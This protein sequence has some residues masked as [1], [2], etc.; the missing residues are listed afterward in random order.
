MPAVAEA[1]SPTDTRQTSAGGR[2]LASVA[3]AGCAA[4]AV[5]LALQHPLAP[6]LALAGVLLLAAVQAAWPPLWL[7]ALPA[8]MPWLGLGAWTGW[9]VVE[10]MDLVLLALAAGA[11]LRWALKPWPQVRAS[12]ASRRMRAWGQLLLML[13]AASVLVGLVRGLGDLGSTGDL[14]LGWWHGW[15]EPLNALRLAKSTVAMLLMLPL[16]WALQQRPNQRCADQLGLGLALALAGT[17]LWCVWERAAFTGLLNMSADYR[18]TGPFWETHVG[19]AALDACLALTLPFALR[20]W[21]TVRSPAALAAA[22]VVVL[23]GVYAGLTTFSRIV[24]LALPV[25]ALVLWWL[26]RQQMP[27]PTDAAP[28][29]STLTALLL[30]LVVGGL[31]VWL[32]PS[33]GYRGLLAL[34][35]NVVVLLLLAPRSVKQSA[36]IWVGAWALGL[37]LAAAVLVAAPLVGKGVYIAYAGLSL[38]TV[39]LLLAGGGSVMRML[40]GAGFVAQLAASAAVAVGW[41]GAAAWPAAAAAALLPALAWLAL[42]TRAQPAWQTD[43]RWLGGVTVMLAMALAAVAVFGGGAFMAS[44]LAQTESD[45]SGRWQ[46]FRDGLALNTGGTALWLGQGLGRYADLY[47]LNGRPETHPGDI[48]LVGTPGD[49]LVRMVAGNHLQGHSEMLR[50]SQRI[51]PPPASGLTVTLE[52]RSSAPVTLVIDLCLKHLLYDTDCRSAS[53]VSLANANGL[54]RLRVRLPDAGP[55][56]ADGLPRFT[57]FSVATETQRQPIDLRSVSLTDASGN[58]LLHNGSFT[59][60][61][62]RWFITSDKHHLPWH[63][64]NL[65]VHLLVEQGLLGLTALLALTLAAVAGLTGSLRQHPLAPALAAALVGCWVVGLVD[66]VLDLP[67]TATWLLLLTGMALN[68]HLPSRAQRREHA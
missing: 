4:L 56:P 34:L 35:G 31:G 27:A 54:Q 37:L 28:A 43:L 1:A 44:R 10:E 39:A 5:W 55:P 36:G 57:V 26:Q 48:R 22:G 2:V 64:K 14:G 25:G 60:G 66:S 67:R 12:R 41:G 24:Y 32:F 42:G 51:A 53:A 52:L 62:A 63:A 6:A 19:G 47:A 61:L 29:R 11:Y 15:R 13:W 49:A 38:V 59:D 9:T 68:L 8:L 45:G 7:I 21:W 23:G 30:C 50:L 18:T 3:A 65:A 46:H 33:A 16:W 20:L 58:A 40:A 17:T